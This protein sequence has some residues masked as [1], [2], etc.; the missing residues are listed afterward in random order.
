MSSL[1]FFRLNHW[2]L[3]FLPFR[4]ASIVADQILYFWWHFLIPKCTMVANRLVIMFWKC[5]MYGLILDVLPLL[6]LY[7]EDS[8]DDCMS[9]LVIGKTF[10]WLMEWWR[11]HMIFFLCVYFYN[12]NCI[13]L[14]QIKLQISVLKKIETSE[15]NEEEN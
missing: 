5:C 15:E 6:F 13:H 9:L 7:F 4:V 11:I 12:K 3:V 8:L 1:I 2:V 14:I 10:G